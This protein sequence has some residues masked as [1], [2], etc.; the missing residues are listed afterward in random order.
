MSI[1]EVHYNPNA[2]PKIDCEFQW[3][4]K[5]LKEGEDPVTSLDRIWDMWSDVYGYVINV[6]AEDII[7]AIT[8]TINILRNSGVNV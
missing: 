4:V 1:Y 7:D 2:G 5:E 8:K 6:E 3:Q